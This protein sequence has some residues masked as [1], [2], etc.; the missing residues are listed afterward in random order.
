M[1]HITKEQFESIGF[2]KIEKN[3]SE[4]LV[5]MVFTSL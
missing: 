2:S 4:H 5:S 1:K 3:P